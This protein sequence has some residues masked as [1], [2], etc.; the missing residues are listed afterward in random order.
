MPARPKQQMAD[1]A[2]KYAHN[3]AHTRRTASL[4]ME[5]SELSHS[6]SGS[7]LNDRHAPSIRAAR[8]KL[9]TAP[10]IE[11]ARDAVLQGLKYML[12]D[13]QGWGENGVIS[14]VPEPGIYKCGE[15]LQKI[16]RCRYEPCDKKA[17][18]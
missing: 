17:G 1:A 12:V 11:M 2:A 6:L 14:V 10:K 9:T 16:K 15:G 5:Y 8:A 4:L 7:H 18:H 3:N 13:G